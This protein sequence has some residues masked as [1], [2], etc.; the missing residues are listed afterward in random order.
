MDETMHI[1]AK[2]FWK[3]VR[4]AYFMWRKGISKGKLLFN[5]NFMMMRGKIAGKLEA[6][7]NLISSASSGRRSHRRRRHL[8]PVKL[9]GKYFKATPPAPLLMDSDLAVQDALEKI[10]MHATG[11]RAEPPGEAAEDNRLSISNRGF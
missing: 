6:I 11:L 4:V 1:L 8:F 2:K 7:H 9:N 5:L 10:D 3:V